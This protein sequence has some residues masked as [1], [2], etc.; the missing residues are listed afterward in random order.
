MSHSNLERTTLVSRHLKLERFGILGPKVGTSR[1][2]ND[3]AINNDSGTFDNNKHGRDMRNIQFNRFTR[4]AIQ[5]EDFK[6]GN[7]GSVTQDTRITLEWGTG[8]DRGTSHRVG[9]HI[10][11]RVDILEFRRKS[12]SD[13]IV[14][15]CH[16]LDNLTSDVGMWLVGSHKKGFTRRH[17]Q[18]VEE[19]GCHRTGIVGELL[20][21][22]KN[23]TSTLTLP[24]W[25]IVRMGVD[26]RLFR[27]Q[28]DKK[29]L[30]VAYR[31][32]LITGHEG[33]KKLLERILL[34]K[35]VSGQKDSQLGFFTDTSS[36][37][38]MLLE[39]DSNFFN[40]AKATHGF[41]G[42]E[43]NGHFR[44]VVVIAVIGR[45]LRVE[46]GGNL[47][48]RMSLN[49][50]CLSC[51]KNLEEEGKFVSESILERAAV[52]QRGGALRVG[53]DPKFSVGC[54][55][56]DLLDGGRFQGVSSNTRVHS[57]DSPGVVLDRRLQRDG[58]GWDF[59]AMISR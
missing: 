29:K 1:T 9:Q 35:I 47:L 15:A 38:R 57:A 3:L 16:A 18:V 39:K 41:K 40:T 46:S 22:T 20:S 6:L 31:L 34:G 25:F 27:L 2:A 23:G 21:Q 30:Q 51:T 37:F 13:D 53:S 50:K 14:A 19:E 44:L 17:E 5:H 33:T 48:V 56:I 59:I 58:V 12:S 24:W 36:K 8:I 26:D 49:R 55:R 42:R 4:S 43:G 45:I 11:K 7:R 32:V 52:A 10:H 54:I 28:S